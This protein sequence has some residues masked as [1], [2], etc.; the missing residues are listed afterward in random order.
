[1][2][3]AITGVYSRVAD[4]GQTATH[5]KSKRLDVRKQRGKI[6]VRARV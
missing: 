3:S 2:N 5:V 1:M 4:A 6:E